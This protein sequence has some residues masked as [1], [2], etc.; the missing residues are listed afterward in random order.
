MVSIAS[1]FIREGDRHD[2]GLPSLFVSYIIA[3]PRNLTENP[4]DL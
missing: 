3:P 2:D 1:V 4:F